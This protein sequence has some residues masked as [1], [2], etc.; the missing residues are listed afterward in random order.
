MTARRYTAEQALAWNLAGYVYPSRE[1]LYA[2]ADQ[3]AADIAK[4][5]PLAVGAVK[6]IVNK[7]EGVDLLTHLDM[8]VTMQ[9][10]LLRTADFQ[11][12]MT[13]LMEKRDPD[14]QRK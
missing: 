2:A 5:A 12:G 3:L 1:D 7:G 9:S 4:M 8:E 11:E 10:M 6:K 13:A 14:W